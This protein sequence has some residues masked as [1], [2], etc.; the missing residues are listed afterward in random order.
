M[1]PANAVRIEELV[2]YFDYGYEAPKADSEEPFAANL[3]CFACPW[4]PEHKLVRI[5]VKGREV[6]VDKRPLSNLVFLIDVSGSMNEPNKLPLVISGL[7]ALVNK[8][9][10][11]DRV[12][13]VVYA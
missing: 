6:A 12:A 1:P 4:K 5:G 11:N 7:N 13:I 3:G 8:L 9:G 10:E 2:N